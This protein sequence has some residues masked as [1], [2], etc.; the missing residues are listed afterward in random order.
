M[1][2]VKHGLTWPNQTFDLPIEID[3]EPVP[4]VALG[5]RSELLMTNEDLNRNGPYILATGKSVSG[6]RL[7]QVT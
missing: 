3:S 6:T 4:N 1:Y 5:N 7:G 2:L